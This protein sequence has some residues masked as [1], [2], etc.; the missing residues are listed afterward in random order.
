M[1][2]EYARTPRTSAPACSQP[3][4]RVCYH[5]GR[6]AADSR[7]SRRS[8]PMTPGAPRG[9]QRPARPGP[10]DRPS[11]CDSHRPCGSRS[12]LAGSTQFA[13]HLLAHGGLPFLKPCIEA[14]EM[15]PQNS[16]HGPDAE[17][18]ARRPDEGVRHWDSRATYA[19]A[20]FRTSRSSVTR[21]SLRF[22][23]LFSAPCSRPASALAPRTA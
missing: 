19:V 15:N 21:A 6:G 3:R 1:T 22:K 23:R 11:A 8:Q 14:A 18:L 7:P 17:L 10:A 9:S 13:A 5:T 20:L 2:P 12:R 4:S 16:A